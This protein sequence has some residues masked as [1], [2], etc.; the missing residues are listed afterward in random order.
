[1]PVRVKALVENRTIDNY[2]LLDAGSTSSFCTTG[3]MTELGVDGKKETLPLTTLKSKDK[4][5]Y[6]FVIGLQV[7]GIGQ[8]DWLELPTVYTRPDLAITC[9]NKATYTDLQSWDHLK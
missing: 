8:Q 2:A 3:L 5:T 6:T 9:L 1:M 4:K 7:C